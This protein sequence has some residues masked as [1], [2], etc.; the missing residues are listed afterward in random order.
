MIAFSHHEH[1]KIIPMQP[2]RIYL[3]KREL[4]FYLALLLLVSGVLADNHDLA[5]SLDNLALF[6]DGFH[7]RSDLH[8]ISL[9]ISLVFANFSAFLAIFISKRTK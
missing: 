4:V 8:C 6:A 7:R 1:N 2:L 3:L 5:I 9:L